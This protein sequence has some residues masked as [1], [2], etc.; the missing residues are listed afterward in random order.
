MPLTDLIKKG[1]PNKIVWDKLQEDSFQN[2]KRQLARRPILRLP[3]IDRPFVLRC[4]ASEAAVGSVL[5]QEHNG[6]LFPVA[7]ASK[8]L[9]PR[10]RVYS[11]MEKEC[12]AALWAIRRYNIYLYGRPFVLQTDHQPLAYLNKAKFT[13]GRILRWALFLQPYRID[14]QAIKGSKN[15][16]ADY[17]SR[18]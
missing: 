2:L 5:L 6:E 14:I 18:M 17:M 8:K 12:L 13:N 3:D 1:R 9:L 7:F 4:D 11:I 16:G 10:E 15:V